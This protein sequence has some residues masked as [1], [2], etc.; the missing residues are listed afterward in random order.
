MSIA[1]DQAARCNCRKTPVGAI[2]VRDDRVISTG[3]NGTIAGFDNCID[4]SCPRCADETVISGTELDRCIC[5]HAEQNALLAAARFG[6][7][8]KRAMCWVTNEP[9]LDCTK[10]LIQAELAEVYYWRP[11]RLEASRDELRRSM[12][13]HATEK[14]DRS[15]ISSRGVLRLLS[16]GWKRATRTS[17]SESQIIGR[18]RR[19]SGKLVVAAAGTSTKGCHWSA[20]RVGRPLGRRVACPPAGADDPPPSYLRLSPPRSSIR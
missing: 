20:D 11:Y 8:V 7:R 4:G 3:Y 6:V 5:V 13:E 19:P 18:K 14:A 15:T 9:C 17:N 10:A 2:I 16:S 12:R 1:V